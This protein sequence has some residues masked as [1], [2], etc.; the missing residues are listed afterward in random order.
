MK[1]ARNL[2]RAVLMAPVRWSLDSVAAKLITTC[3]ARSK[4]RRIF[5]RRHAACLLSVS[6]DKSRIEQKVTR[7]EEPP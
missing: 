1:T 3:R 2:R 5:V 6:L 7:F 4:Y